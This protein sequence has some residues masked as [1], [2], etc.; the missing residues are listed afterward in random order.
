MYVPGTKFKVVLKI[1]AG[2]QVFEPGLTGEIVGSV[3]KMVGKSYKVKFD[4]G[5]IAE[6]HMVIMNNQAQVIKDSL[7]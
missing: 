5:R 4:D 3:N 1:K 7:N 2:E 6:I